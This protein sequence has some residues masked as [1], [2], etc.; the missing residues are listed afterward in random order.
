[1]IEEMVLIDWV[2]EFGFPMAVCFWFMFRT[3]NVIKKN[4]EVMNKLLGKITK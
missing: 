3:E 2:K 1:M 4:T